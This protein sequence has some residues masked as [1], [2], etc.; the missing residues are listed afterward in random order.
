MLAAGR[1]WHTPMNDDASKVA[2]DL[3]KRI[4]DE[5]PGLEVE[6]WVYD[7]ERFLGYRVTDRGSGRSKVGST[8]R[9][10]LRVQWFREPATVGAHLHSIRNWL[11][12]GERSL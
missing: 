5:F 4:R 3:E 9:E 2:A 7:S 11:E 12:K 1:L 6:V 8:P 10:H